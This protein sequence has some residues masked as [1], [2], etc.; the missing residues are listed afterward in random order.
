[1][2]NKIFKKVVS[3]L[4]VLG[5]AFQA[6]PVWALTKDETIYTKL[7]SDGSVST[8]VASEHISGEGNDKSKLNNIK[9][10][11][12]E[13]KYTNN[14]G[15]L[16]WENNG[17]D[18]YYQ[19]TS[20]EELPISTSIKYYLDD[21]EM[22]VEDMIGKKGNVKI[23]IH[24]ENNL[25]HYELVNG[26]AEELYTP[27][28][29]ATTSIISN[30]DNK[31]ISV[32]NGKVIDNGVS[33]IVVGLSS[34]G[35]YES[36]D[37]DE[38]KGF[39]T[40]EISY[41]TNNF[42]LNSIYSAASARLYDNSDL[43]VF[44]NVNKLYDV[45][46]SLQSNM[47]TIVDGANQL[48]EG[49]KKL[50]NGTKQLN[51]GVNTLTNK[52]YSY[53]NMDKDELEKQIMSLI[54]SNLEQLVPI[55]EKDIEEEISKIIKDNKASLEESA[56]EVTKKNVKIVLNNEIDNI[57]KDFNLNGLLE[58]I[59][60]SDL[61][62]AIL[63]DP[64]IQ[65]IIKAFEDELTTELNA[66][67]NNTTKTI[68]KGTISTISN[69]LNQ[70][71]MTDEEKVQYIQSIADKYGITFE[72][73]AGIVSEVKGDTIKGI[74]NN[75]N[76]QSDSISTQV[77]NQVSNQ[78]MSTLSN[79]EF[80]NNAM[81]H[82]LEEVNKKLAITLDNADIESYE[83]NLKEELTKIIRNRL[84]NNENI[85]KYMNVSEYTDSVIN[86]IIDKTAKDLASMYTAE[87][88][89][90][91]TT[92][93]I[94]KEFS[95]DNL[96]SELQKI[97]LSYEAEIEDKLNTLDGAITTLSSSVSQLN[98]G[99]NQLSNG[100]NILNDG[101]NRYNT[102]GIQKISGFVNGDLKSLEGKVEALAKLS[103]EYKTFDDT[104]ENAS[105]S[106]KIIMVVDSI[107]NEEKTTT[108]KVD[109][110]EEDKSFWGKIKGLFN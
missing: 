8:Y 68:V 88:A 15:E 16:V 73:A 76:K 98:D 100:M 69:S 5:I 7:N 21:K 56:I 50:A 60:N 62:N 80:V 13:E 89:K 63:S 20:D 32:T 51:D 84:S 67:V 77:A 36:L 31:N 66:E 43:D 55:L 19:G 14:N 44:G 11:N 104:P 18:I 12:G 78:V 97:L 3:W 61:E 81:N 42:E 53:R 99:A 46:N 23:V 58:D 40:V 49:S 9:N 54:E 34:P 26:K 92:N 110:I 103:E 59:I 94:Q 29:V 17:N 74:Q 71:T 39:D 108:T 47:D 30:T 22:N 4:I 93:V 64:E 106:S 105:G 90:Q 86:T 6:T 52:Y 25:K 33:S 65:N 83:Q 57:I 48:N 82:Y 107:R 91:V 70:D 75:L 10:V 72:Q 102:E 38:L 85:E 27:F 87:F 96:E 2:K 28:I 37:I 41:E 79:K 1:M 101:L 109:V 24:Y 45:I 95:K 35:L